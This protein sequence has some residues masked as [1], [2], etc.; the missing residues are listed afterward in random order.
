MNYQG[1]SFKVPKSVFLENPHNERGA[2]AFAR[3][4]A[5]ARA[6]TST[7]ITILSYFSKYSNK[8]NKQNKINNI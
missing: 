4:E 3:S 2:D 8:H 5:A 1:D 6:R 7:R